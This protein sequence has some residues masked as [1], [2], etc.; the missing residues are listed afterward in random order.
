MILCILLL[1]ARRDTE[2]CVGVCMHMLAFYVGVCIYWCIPAV[3]SVPENFLYSG[4][5]TARAASAELLQLTS[6]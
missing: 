4:Y 2:E 3:S 1:R 5:P 6:W